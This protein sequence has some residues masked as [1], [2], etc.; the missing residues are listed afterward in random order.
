MEL[1]VKKYDELSVDELYE[2]LKLRN[3]VFVVE[4]NCV[5]QD[6]DD[7][8]KSAYH[9]WLSDGQITAYLRIIPDDG[10]GHAVIGRVISVSR[11]C[12]MGTRVLQEGI[13]VVQE[14]L[15]VPEIRIHAQAYARK[16]YENQDFVQYGEEF[17]EDGIPHIAMRL[18]L[19]REL[20]NGMK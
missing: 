1:H 6:C 2:I 11:R 13:K 16:L 12:G 17:L 10:E 9:V 14:R 19:H 8:D 15:D 5:Y 20:L 7:K 4:Q 18:P 3:E